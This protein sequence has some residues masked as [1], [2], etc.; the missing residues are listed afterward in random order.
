MRQGDTFKPS[1]YL[2][3][4]TISLSLISLLN[5]HAVENKRNVDH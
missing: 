2:V 5:G 3:R 1:A 4:F